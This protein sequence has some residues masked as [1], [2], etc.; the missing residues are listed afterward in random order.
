MSNINIGRPVPPAFRQMPAAQDNQSVNGG[1]QPNRGRLAGANVRVRQGGD[2]ASSVQQG[3]QTR[4]RGFF[5]KLGRRIAG[6]FVAVV[7]TPLGVVAGAAKGVVVGVKTFATSVGQLTYGGA[8][9]AAKA[10][11]KKLPVLG[12]LFGGVVGGAVGLVGGL[13]VG[14]GRGVMEVGAS[15]IQV[16]GLA[17]AAGRDIMSNGLFEAKNHAQTLRNELGKPMRDTEVAGQTSLKSKGNGRT[18]LGSVMSELRVATGSRISE[19]QMRTYINMGEHIAK[20]IGQQRNYA[21]GPITVRDNDGNSHVVKPNL[22]TTRALSWYLQA[23]ALVDNNSAGL[24]SEHCLAAMVKGAMVINDPGG[25]AFQFLKSSNNTYGRASTHFNERGRG[26]KATFGNTGFA[27]MLAGLR[28]QGAQFGIEDF[29]NKM[30]S[31]GGCLLFEQLPGNSDNQQLFLKWE[32]VGMPDVFGRGTHADDADGWTSKVQNR[33][34]AQSRCMGHTM[35]FLKGHSSENPTFIPRREAVNKGAPE[36]LFQ[37]YA[38]FQKKFRKQDELSHIETRTGPIGSAKQNLE[39]RKAKKTGKKLAKEDKKTGKKFGL[40]VM[41]RQLAA[42]IMNVT[43]NWDMAA[44][45]K[46]ELMEEAYE[47]RTRLEDFKD[48]MGPYMG[49]DRKGAE[50]HANLV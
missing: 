22:E 40:G 43:E 26:Q 9:V 3:S 45:K 15:T 31:G 18:T 41:E 7:G 25:N 2:S 35:N 49:I 16:A 50:I 37:D 4:T 32:S 24:R 21:G 12:G 33:Y 11:H 47:L 34:D 46:E 1:V 6:G 38:K 5:N 28:G 39:E 17:L 14:A 13:V 42:D 27:G 23:K 29:G 48:D 10:G 44:K 8:K 20:E 30:P 19:P 36:E